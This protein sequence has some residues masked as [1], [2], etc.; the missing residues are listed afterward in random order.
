MWFEQVKNPLIPNVIKIK[1]KKIQITFLFLLFTSLAFAY[2]GLLRVNGKQIV[3]AENS[4]V[5]LKGINLGN[6]LEN[7]PYMMG[8]PS[9]LMSLEKHMKTEM[10]DLL[11]DQT[12]VDSFYNVFETNYVQKIDI[13]KIAEWGMNSIRIPLDATKLGFYNPSNKVYTVNEKGYAQIDSVIKWARPYNIYI[14]LDMH[15][16]PGGSGASLHQFNFDPN[17]PDAIWNDIDLQDE[18][19]AA[20]HALASRYVNDDLVAGYDLMNEPAWDFKDNNL[21]KP[22]FNLYKRTTAAIREVDTRHIIYFEGNGYSWDFRG[23]KVPWDNNMVY[24]FHKYLSWQVDD[25]DVNEVVALR[26]GTNRPVWNGE[27]GENCNLWL[28]NMAKRYE[29]VNIGWCSW[30]TKKMISVVGPLAI[31][32][33]PLYIALTKYWEYKEDPTKPYVAKPS[34]SE[35]FTALMAQAELCKFSNCTFHKD[36]IDALMRQTQSDTTI[37]WKNIVLPEIIGRT[38]RINA[39]EFDLGSVGNA[40]QTSQHDWNSFFTFRNDEINVGSFIG[41]ANGYVV[42]NIHSDNTAGTTEWTKYTVTTP[43]KGKYEVRIRYWAV[44]L[45]SAPSISVEVNGKMVG[46]VP[47]ALKTNGAFSTEFIDEIDIEKGKT[48]VI[49]NYFGTDFNVSTIDF[50]LKQILPTALNEIKT[51]SSKLKIITSKNSISFADAQ[52]SPAKI[53]IYCYNGQIIHSVNVENPCISSIQFGYNSG[54][55][56]VSISYKNGCK[57]IGKF[58]YNF[59]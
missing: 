53:D 13:D 32:M 46:T 36:Y 29:A 17:A 54:I 4:N 48:Q 19:V 21:N 33:S 26:D 24:A 16:M 57:Q 40:Y 47:Y 34:A 23:L 6:W 49:L 18:F 27:T 12:K 20:W 58:I 44:S 39:S 1:M 42:G 31:P 45:T 15:R 41:E 10:L 35:T 14:I 22:L 37:A 25:Y 5:L 11:G 56:L 7:E 30:P 38:T 52:S 2:T 51:E 43:I 55:Y 50:K 59:R 8:M 28:T 3:D 9:N